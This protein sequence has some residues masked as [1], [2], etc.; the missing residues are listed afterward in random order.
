FIR[1]RRSTDKS[2]I[3]RN[4]AWQIS[5]ATS[6]PSLPLFETIVRGGNGDTVRVAVADLLRKTNLDDI[7]YEILFTSGVNK[8]NTILSKLDAKG[9]RAPNVSKSI[10]F[11]V[12][13]IFHVNVDICFDYLVKSADDSHISLISEI[14]STY[15]DHF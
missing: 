9:F 2:R 10:S 15:P 12:K 3:V 4:L 7:E 13:N 8:D 5:G 11:L 14:I 6:H 1:Q